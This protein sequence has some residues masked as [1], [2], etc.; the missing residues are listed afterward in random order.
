MR[1]E[2]AKRLLEIV[3]G[4]VSSLNVDGAKVSIRLTSNPADMDE[5]HANVAIDGATPQMLTRI[6]GAGFYLPPVDG[7]RVY[8]PRA[9]QQKKKDQTPAS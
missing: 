5:P 9:T 7:V 4:E 1:L 8:G 2:E 6:E 3:K